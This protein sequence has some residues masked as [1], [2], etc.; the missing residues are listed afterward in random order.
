MGSYSVKWGSPKMYV[1][2]ELITYGI[3]FIYMYSI[4]TD[5]T[6]LHSKLTFKTVP[7][8]KTAPAVTKRKKLNVRGLRTTDNKARLQNKLTEGL[9]GISFA[10]QDVEA[11]WKQFRDV[12]LE[13]AQSTLGSEERKH[14]DWF[15]ENDNIIQELLSKQ[16]E[17]W[18]AWIGD[19]NSQR[20]ETTYKAL[21]AKTQTKLRQVKDEWWR[22][23]AEE[24]QG[25][26]DANATKL[27]YDGLKSVFGPISHAMAPV[28]T[29]EGTL[30]TDKQ[31]ILKR[32][33]EHFHS[34]LNRPSTITTEALIRIPQRP[35]ITCLDDPPSLDEVSKAVKQL[36]PGKAAGPDG[37]PPDIYKEGGE[38]LIVKLTELLQFFWHH[39]ELPQD[40]KDANIIHLYKR[41]GDKSSC[42]NHR[43]ISPLSVAGK[44]LACVLVNRLIKHL[45]NDVVSESQ[46]G[47]RN[48][49]GT[50]DM[51][52]SVRQLQ[53]KCRKQRQ[54]LYLLFVDLTK[55]FDTVCR[56]GLWYI[57]AKLGC[58]AK[59]THM[60]RSFH[61][62]MLARVLEH[63][64]VS[65]PIPVTNGVKQGCVL[66]PTLFSILFATM[67]QQALSKSNAGV[68]INCRT[69][70]KAF[71]LRR[72]KAKTKVYEALLRDFLFADDCALAA[73]SEEDLQELADNLSDA[74]SDFGLT[75]S[76]KKSEV[77]FQPTQQVAAD[78]PVIKIQGTQLNNV[79]EFT[80]LGSRVTS[81]CSLDK[82][83]SSRL[84]KGSSSFG[85]L[86]TRVWT[87]RGI[88]LSTKIAV[89]RAVV[90]TSLLYGC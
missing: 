4:W 44:I 83:T 27:F 34:L 81:D 84:A 2:V 75:I 62:G 41:K 58:P 53:E 57:L 38:V 89:Y 6:L 46:C 80:Y 28:R 36:Q 54:D 68:S 9:A 15:D 48:N 71:D 42:D 18:S 13:A 61:D 47:F 12:V 5:H 86:W 64:M 21:K 77:L 66:A 39:D 63:G 32:W 73:T 19:K 7:T 69:D 49:R 45:L 8:K 26:A 55:A 70:G 65:E 51:I 25:Y 1:I 85:R 79:Q 37:I 76:L 17:A 74:C 20:K 52:F 22:A 30:L 87:E 59:F 11:N 3:P 23:K 88:K 29:S 90:L 14:Q 72:L 10:E 60:V 16:H 50:V 56:A 35:L 82:E 33:T 67:L 24:L 78:G 40:L 43:G 31:D